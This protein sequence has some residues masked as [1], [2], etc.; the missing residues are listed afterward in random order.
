[1]QLLQWYTESI[2]AKQVAIL[3]LFGYR[4]TKDFLKQMQY[5]FPLAEANITAPA[6]ILIYNW[7]TEEILLGDGH[8]SLLSDEQV[9]YPYFKINTNF[10]KIKYTN[11][12]HVA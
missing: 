4:V 11:T 6:N 3:R 7:V 2:K 5:D 8:R 10:W 1:L 9:H 12:L